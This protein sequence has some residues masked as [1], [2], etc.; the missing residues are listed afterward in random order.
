MFVILKRTNYCYYHSNL[1]DLTVQKLRSFSLKFRVCQPKRDTPMFYEKF[2][3]QAFKGEK[4]YLSFLMSY[5]IL[6]IC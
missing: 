6:I 5:K 4:I 3:I 1:K 2:R